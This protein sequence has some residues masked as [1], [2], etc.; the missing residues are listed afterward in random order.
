MADRTLIRAIVLHAQVAPDRRVLDVACGAGFLLQAYRDVGA[1][2][3]GVDISEAML[4]A[5]VR[6]LAAYS[7]AVPLVQADAAR[8]PFAAGSFHIALCKLAFHYFRQPDQVLAELARVCE[9]GGRV[10]LVDRVT[11]ESPELCDAQNDLE[12][13]RTPNKVRVYSTEELLALMLEAG[14]AVSNRSEHCQTMDFEEWMAAAGASPLIES[15]RQALLEP[16]GP[17]ARAFEPVWECG[18][19][20]IK[21]RTAILVAH[22]PYLA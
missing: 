14:L 13:R 2:C 19:L 8:L 5:A 16:G 17:L 6:T 10:V 21:H 3:V 7:P 22:T 18:R 15:T 4:G 11:A 1:C 9:P 12:R 20:Y